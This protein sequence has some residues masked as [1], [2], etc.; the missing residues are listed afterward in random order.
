M[1]Q[2][3]VNLWGM[4]KIPH[5]FDG[6]V[7]DDPRNGRDWALTYLWACSMDAVA[8]GPVFMVLSNIY[9][10]LKLPRKR[11]PGSIALGLG[12]LSC[13]L[14]CLGAP[15]AFLKAL[16]PEDEHSLK[17]DEPAKGDWSPGMPARFL[18][19]AAST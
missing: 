7:A 17:A 19:R 2:A 5:V 13:G 18:N 1:R 12:S 6:N 3:D 14:F 9:M 4:M 15:L 8:G 10:W 16:R 11:L